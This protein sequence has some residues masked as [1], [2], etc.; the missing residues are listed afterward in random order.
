MNF[1]KALEEYAVAHLKLRTN[2]LRKLDQELHYPDG[3]IEGLVNAVVPSLVG[4]G[5]SEAQAAV[6]PNSTP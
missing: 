2:A 3:A 1:W 4:Q 5:V 6:Q